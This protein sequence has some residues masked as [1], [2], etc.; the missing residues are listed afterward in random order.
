MTPNSTQVNFDPLNPTDWEKSTYYS[1]DAQGNV[2]AI[3]EYTVV[4]STQQNNYTLTERT[5]YGSSRLGNN[6]KTVEMIAAPPV[7]TSKYEHYVGYRQY[8]LSNHLGNVMAVVSDRKIARDTSANDTVDY[9]EPDVLLTFDYSPFGAP[10]HA[11]SFSKEVCHDTTFTMVVEDLNTNFDDGTTMGWQPLS[12]STS[13]NATGGTLNLQKQGGSGTVGAT[14][15]FTAINGEDYDFTITVNNP[16]NSSTV[17]VLELLDA[18]NTVIY[19]QSVTSPNT[20]TFNYQFTAATG[21]VYTV[22]VYRT[23]NNSASCIYYIDDVLITH[24]EDVQQ[25]VCEEFGGYR[26]GFNGMEKDNE[27]KGQGNSYDFG[28]RIYDSRLG[29][30]LAV[31]PL[32]GKYP[33]FSPY[34]FGYNNPLVTI[35]PNGEENIVVVGGADVSGKDREKFFN[36][37]L[38]AINDFL[39]DPTQNKES[40]TLVV[41]TAFLTEI[42]RTTLTEKIMEL[43]QDGKN[44]NIA[45]AESADELTNYMN[46]KTTQIPDEISMLDEK[47]GLPLMS[48][49]TLKSSRMADKITDVK[50]FGHGYA[51]STTTGPTFESGHGANITNI[52][53]GEDPTSY[54]DKFTWGIKQVKELNRN[55]FNSP[56]WDFQSCNAGTKAIKGPFKNMSLVTEVVKQTGGISSGWWGKS[57]Y[58]TIYGTGFGATTTWGLFNDDIDPASNDPSAGE[59]NDGSGPAERVSAVEKKEP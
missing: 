3:Y 23:G 28:A 10:L 57:D 38:K 46:L 36:T 34:H 58:A 22:K 45:F 14:Q 35:D 1:R 17:I 27:I 48:E 56:N 7:D 55:A 21:G 37:G 30:W 6:H 13:M 25:T 26:Y 12:S 19:T 16:C 44:V 9:Y 2:M 18:N 24:Q 49:E 39:S 29:R 31:D 59:K 50:I 47:T 20:T 11:R 52:P 41:M 54:H 53:S 42:E 15:S 51:N 5:I 40:T 4:D 32:I 33:K 8:E 43:Q